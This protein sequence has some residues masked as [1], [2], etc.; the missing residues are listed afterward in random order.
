MARQ[1]QCTLRVADNT[2][3]KGRIDAYGIQGIALVGPAGY[4]VPGSDTRA[5]MG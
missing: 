3:A 5:V 4:C 1:Q 2:A